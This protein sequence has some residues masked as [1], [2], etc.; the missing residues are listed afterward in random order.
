MPLK[1]E[2][3]PQELHNYPLRVKKVNKPCINLMVFYVKML[4]KVSIIE[5]VFWLYFYNVPEFH[6]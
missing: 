1:N 6:W 4:A 3:V 2:E 5:P